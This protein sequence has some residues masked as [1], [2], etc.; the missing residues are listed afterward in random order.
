MFLRY[1]AVVWCIFGRS[2]NASLSEIMQKYEKNVQISA[3]KKREKIC[4]AV[5]KHVHF[6][7]KLRASLKT[8]RIRRFNL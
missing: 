3:K 1:F 8:G 6:R 5:Q 7:W 2:M 4:K